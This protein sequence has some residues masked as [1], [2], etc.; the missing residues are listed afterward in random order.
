[1]AFAHGISN[2]N[3]TATKSVSTSNKET[4]GVVI[5]FI[6]KASIVL[7]EDLTGHPLRTFHVAMA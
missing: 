1:L 4:K 5:P 3:T 7:S 6:G 2:A